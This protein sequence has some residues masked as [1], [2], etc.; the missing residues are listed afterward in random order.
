M[1]YLS[2]RKISAIQKNQE[3]YSFINNELRNELEELNMLLEKKEKENKVPFNIQ[4]KGHDVTFDFKQAPGPGSYNLE[5]PKKPIQ[6]GLSPFLF[7]SQRFKKIR[8][9]LNIPGPGSYNIGGFKLTLRRNKSQ[10]RPSSNVSNHY[11]ISS[12]NNVAT[13]PAKK[14]E[15]GYNIDNNGD[16]I[17]AVD[18]IADYCFSGTKNDSIGPGRYNPIIKEKNHCVRWDK[19]SGRKPDS[20]FG[21]NTEN[22]KN[23]M[24]QNSSLIDTDISSLKSSNERKHVKKPKPKPFRMITYKSQRTSSIIQD[25]EEKIDI[26]K[27]IDFLTHKNNII[28]GPKKSRNFLLNYNIMR[29]ASK[30]EEFQFFGSSNERNTSETLILNTNTKV[31]P[32]SYF[33]NTYK[34]FENYYLNKNIQNSWEKTKGR[35]E[36]FKLKRSLSNLGPGSYDIDRSLQKKSFNNFGNFS[37]EKRF[38]LSYNPQTNIENNS[39]EGGNPGPGSYNINDPWIKDI[40]KMVKKPILVNVLEEMKKS[41][42]IKKDE[43]KPDF[44]NYQSDGYINAIQEKIRKKAN[45]YTSENMPF[46]S[47]DNRFKFINQDNHENI[48]PGKYELLNK[49]NKVRKFYSILAPFSS[50]EERKPA[51]VGKSNNNIAPGEHSKD[52]YFDWNKKSFNAMFMN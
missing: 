40:T 8:N 37:T 34:K 35:E 39:Q 19:S 18:P 51:Y 20:L 45:P 48:G 16:L 3:P 42:K 29:K 14:Q 46:L 41:Q 36:K 52:S 21:V 44:N 28:S 1:V 49:G 32:G 2:D 15:F 25:E 13:I 17:P 7:K 47:G 12:V 43:N 23:E 30:P 33:R 11:S 6:N 5:P 10:I 9:E 31:G 24:T 27:E 38:D 50:L 4:S 22:L 26:K